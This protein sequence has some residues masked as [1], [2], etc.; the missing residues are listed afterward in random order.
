MRKL[1]IY[2]PYFDVLHRFL[3]YYL[4]LWNVTVGSDFDVKLSVITLDLLVKQGCDGRTDCYYAL[5]ETAG[6]VSD[7]LSVKH[8]ISA[9]FAI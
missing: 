9:R 6:L 7:A 1:F 2:Q 5:Q 4:L 3:I 8:Y